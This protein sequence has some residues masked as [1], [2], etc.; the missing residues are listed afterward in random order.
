M[1]DAGTDPFT[2]LPPAGA[3]AAPPSAAG[4]TAPP[5]RAAPILPAP[6]ALPEAIQ[7]R[8]HGAPSMVWRYRDAAGA[9]L[10]A[11]CRFDPP[12]RRKEVLP[13]TCGAEGWHWKAPPEPRP[14]YGLD[15]LATRPDALVLLVEGEKAADA[16]A[17]LFPDHV[18]MTWQGGGSAIGTADWRPLAG[19]RV[20]VWPDNDAPGRKAASAARKAASA[21]GTARLGVVDVPASWPEGWDLADP[22]PEGATLETLAAMLAAAEAEPVAEDTAA[23]APLSAADVQAVVERA[24]DMNGASY[25]AARA[26]LAAEVPGVGVTGLD[27]LRREER[28]RRAAERREAFDTLSDHAALAEEPEAMPPPHGGAAVRWPPGFRMKKAGLFKEGDDG[29]ARIAGPFA[30]LGRS[31][32]AGSNGWGLALEWADYSGGP[33]REV[34]PARLIHAEPGALETRLH[35]GG[36]F[37]SPDPG[38]RLALRDALAGLKTTARVRKVSRCGWHPSPAGGA[39]AFVLPDG[40]AIGATAEPLILEAASPELAA[41]CGIAGTLDGW[42]AEVAARAV[43]NPAAAFSI[44]AAFAGP[45]L[46]LAAEPSGG[47]H[48]AGPSKIGKTTA[49]QA[50]VSVWG[51]PD[52]RGA[53]RDW[54]STAN[55]MEVALEEA[56]DGLLALD[57]ISQADPRELEAAIYMAANEG[58]KGRLRTDATARAR[59]SWRVLILSTG[60]VSPAQRV[61][62]AGKALRPG[63][64]V[65][66]PALSFALEAGAMWPAL[67]GAAD[68]AGLWRGLHEAM[69]R[70]HG[71]AARAFLERLAAARATDEAVLREAIAEARRAF[72]V[73]YLP[74]D[75]PDQARTVALRF[76]LVAA[77]GDMA[78]DM[79]VLPWPEGEATR[80]AAAGLAAWLADRGGAGSGE[81]AAALV[82]VRAFIERHGEARFALVETAKDGTHEAGGDGRPVI[83]RAGWRFR[84]RD[85]KGWR[86]LVLPEVW[87]A[88]VCAGLDPTSVAKALDRAGKLVPGDG[89]N[90]QRREWVPAEGGQRRGYVIDGSILD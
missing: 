2:P 78:A 63:A 11:V 31:R 79:G 13:Y 59:R 38:D 69:R 18:V 23:P 20:A 57:E 39:P 22:L 85:N 88:E 34:I 61:A 46:D 25:A 87:R 86:F 83:N 45:L 77:A 89:R 12:G 56:T 28:A 4:G 33:H 72:L 51:L 49:M 29:G 90:L 73:K 1:I 37:V 47:F 43:G 32:D 82:A 5:E 40:S 17:A 65:R 76:A 58:G 42:Q 35:E 53:L 16:A 81:D 10:F 9:L 3:S 55:A 52:K 14:L 48:I 60:E 75:A 68:R 71:T 74:A 62:E 41:R 24:A 36:L 6:L 7:H 27:R 80:A 67:H 30:V 50:G 54:R 66:L 8:R 19:R 64:E 70:H 21:A 26:S 15:R 84:L 44:A